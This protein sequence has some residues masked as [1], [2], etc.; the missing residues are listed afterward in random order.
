[1]GFYGPQSGYGPGQGYY[2]DYGGDGGQWG[3]GRRDASPNWYY[4][5]RQQFRDDSRNRYD[6]QSQ[7][8]N[9]WR[10]GSGYDSRGSGDYSNRYDDGSQQQ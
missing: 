6:G 9:D 8:D 5:D 3:Y 2:G 4:Q 1:M 7:Y 10:S